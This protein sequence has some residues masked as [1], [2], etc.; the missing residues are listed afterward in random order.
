MIEDKKLEDGKRKILI[1]IKKLYDNLSVKSEEN[2][3]NYEDLFFLNDEDWINNKKNIYIKYPSLAFYLI[4]YQNVQREFKHDISLIKY[5]NNT[6]PLF[7]HF[8]RIYSSENCLVSDAY[9]NYFISNEISKELKNQ[10]FEHLKSKE[11]F[12][13]NWVGLLTKIN[14][15]KNIIS[16]KIDNLYKY[17][18]NLSN[19]KGNPDKLTEK[20]ISKLIKSLIKILFNNINNIE[21]L[22]SQNIQ[23]EEINY[24]SKISKLLGNQLEKLKNEDIEISSILN[25]IKKMN[26]LYQNNNKIIDELIASI[27][28]DIADFKKKFEEKEIINQKNNISQKAASLNENVNKYKEL[29]NKIKE[30]EFENF[31]ILSEKCKELK[32]I[33]N[34]IRSE[35]NIFE[36]TEKIILF[37]YKVPD[38]KYLYN[39]LI[40]KEDFDLSKLET[41]YKYF[42]DSKNEDTLL[43]IDK[44]EKILDEKKVKYE[45]TYFYNI[46]DHLFNLKKNEIKSTKIKEIKIEPKIIING[47][48]LDEDFEKSN[49]IKNFDKALQMLDNL[50]K[51]IS[52]NKNNIK[53][54]KSNFE[55]L[56]IKF[57]NINFSSPKIDDNKPE[58]TVEICHKIDLFKN[59]I[60]NLLD[61]ILNK[62][63]KFQ[64]IAFI[65]NQDKKIIPKD[66]DLLDLNINIV[67]FDKYKLGFSDKI[68][69]I[70]IS[71]PYL[72]YSHES[73]TLQFCLNKLTQTIGPIIPSL[74]F[75]Q[76][77]NIKIVS[78]V[79]KNIYAN[80]EFEKND[81]YSSLFNVPYLIYGSQPI[82]ISF[83]I[84]NKTFDKKFEEKVKAKLN[85][86]MNEIDKPL[87]IN[88]EFILKFDSLKLN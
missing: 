38:K 33:E 23:N 50:L 26:T 5:S 81:E 54:S 25:E 11:N 3:L 61:N 1:L 49:I 77:Y 37:S 40:D 65:I 64:N 57:K 47:E 84:P 78:F 30:K 4:K 2:Y 22:F 51:N 29:Y 82:Q 9:L 41:F 80:L 72:S 17:L 70:N 12:N 28:N 15:G 75:N 19:L 66:F 10:I 74:F 53:H 8:L 31:N 62:Y 42:D 69:K 67:D 76:R 21:N 7:L 88:C 59:D 16:E 86:R 48:E 63:N 60:L 52:K 39:I 6:F 79:H 68:N 27:K 85:L 36:E 58:E 14:F 43:K 32:K 24:I 35:G 73:N 18:Y 55:N 44:R 71:S 83:L 13:L 87:I 20:S 45:K 56:N 46:N 34:K